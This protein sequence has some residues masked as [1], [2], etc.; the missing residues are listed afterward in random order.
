MEEKF[1]IVPLYIVAEYQRFNNG[2]V[3]LEF[4]KNNAGKWVI[5]CDS[6]IEQIMDCSVFVKA[7]LTAEDFPTPII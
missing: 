7:N 2:V 4:R 6:G 1:Y 3:A 5:N